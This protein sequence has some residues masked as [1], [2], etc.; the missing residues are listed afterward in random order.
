MAF[1][2]PADGLAIAIAFAIAIAI[3]F[4]FAWNPQAH[5]SPSRFR[6]FALSR[7][8]DSCFLARSALAL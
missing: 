3:A 2:K 4:A 1:L 6:A 5:V 8:L 7:F